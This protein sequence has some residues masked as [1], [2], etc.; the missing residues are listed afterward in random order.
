[1]PVRSL[2]TPTLLCLL[3]ALLYTGCDWSS[4]EAKKEKHRERAETYFEKGQYHEAIIEYANVTKIDPKDANAYYQVALIHM[5]LGGVVNLQA[6]YAELT[7]SLELDKT[8]RDAQLKLGELYLIANE[9]TK[10]REQADIVLVSTPQ[11]Q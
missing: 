9:P 2:I 11:N 4:P 1:M 7:R 5:K 8:N 10:A 6:A 3:A